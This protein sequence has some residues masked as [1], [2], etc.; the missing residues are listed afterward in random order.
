[1]DV[2]KLILKFTWK[3]KRPRIANTI[4]RKN[5]RIGE[6]TLC[7]LRTFDKAAIIKIVWYWQQKGKTDPWNRIKDP[8]NLVN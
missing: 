8:F 2:N 4:L 1:M 3:S 5:Y 6:L 7:S